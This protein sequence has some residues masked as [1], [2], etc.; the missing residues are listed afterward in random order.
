MKLIKY[1]VG[2]LMIT[3]LL[4]AGSSDYVG[5]YVCDKGSYVKT[6]ELHSDGFGAW[7]YHNNKSSRY[8]YDEKISWRY[9][10]ANNQIIIKTLTQ[11]VDTRINKKGH[12]FFLQFVANGLQPKHSEEVFLKK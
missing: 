4:H 11:D 12:E 8:D 9:D 1:I 10:K 2:L 5:K 7:T 3:G 6:V